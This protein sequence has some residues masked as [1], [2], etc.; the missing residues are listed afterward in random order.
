MLCP[1]RLLAAGVVLA[2]STA[3][4]DSLPVF[5]ARNVP[6]TFFGTVVDDPYRDLENVKDPKVVG[7]MKAH[8]THARATLDALPGYQ[9]MKARIVELDS[10]VAAVIG[11]VERREGGHLFFTRRAA[12]ANTFKLYHRGPDGRETLLAD[13]DSWE[14]ETGRPHALNYFSPSPDGRYVAYGISAAGS[15]DAAIHVIETA[16]LKRAS[17]PIERAQYPNISW[18]P[19]SRSFFYLRQQELKPGMPATDRY[20]DGRSWRHTVG[21]EPTQ[22]VAVAGPALFPQVAVRPTDFAFVVAVPGSKHALQLVVAGVQREF[23]LYTAP[24]ET[25]GR[26]GTPWVRVCDFADEA[27]SFAVRGD[28]VYLLTHRDSPRFSVIKTSLDAPDVKGAATVIAGSDQVVFEI[29]AARDGLY[30]ESRDGAVKR[31]KRLAWS[32]GAPVEVTLPLEGAASIMSA[33]PDLDGAVVSL[34][35]W[36]RAR[37]IYAVDA[38]GKATNT[39]LQPLGR[40]DSPSDLV[41]AEVQVRSHDG[42]LVPLSITHKRGLNLDGQNPTLLY[43]YGSYGITEEPSFRANRLAWLE[44]GGVYAVANVRG[45]GV[46]GQDWYKA[47]YKATKPNTWKDFIACAE[48]L[49]AQ[50]YTTSAR[51][52]ILGGSAGGILVGRAMTERPDLFAAVVPAVGAL[53]M[54]RMETTANGVPNIPEFGTVKKEDEFRALL[55]MSSYHHVKS[56]TAYPAAMLP[57]GVNDPRVDV[58]HSSKMA[59]R[60]LAA[61]TSGKPVLLNLDYEA[62]HGVG[63]TKE[64]QQRNTADIYSFLFWQTGHPDFQ[65][66]PAK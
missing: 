26:P 48:Y 6:E 57:H 59:A 38:A 16:T 61:T 42:A 27:T 30:F 66:G 13:P 15:E 20:K 34:T 36:T 39:G 25:V 9:G 46:Y 64:Q 14:K 47:G 65:P 8:A 3:W 56:G 53:D 24:L 11:A 28:D 60:L 19:D 2:S 40:F 54:V 21:T 49:V 10:S 62:G 58:W 33:S 5:P 43:G 41:T 45:S 51:L 31:L 18:H 44:R 35:A 7:W 17:G 37:E 23:A 63:S 12:D 55:A 52:G 1:S 22:D 29:A 32:G 50:R 4:A